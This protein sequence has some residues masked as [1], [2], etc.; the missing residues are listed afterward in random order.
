MGTIVQIFEPRF[1]EVCPKCGSRTTQKEDKFFCK[2]HDIVE[3]AFSYVFNVSLDDGTGTI[4]IGLFRNQAERLAGKT[5]EEMLVYRES[6]EKF[7]DVKT[8]ILGTIVKFVGR[9]RKNE[10]FDRLEFNA[11]FVDPSPNPEQELER[12][13]KEE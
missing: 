1:F 3:P 7:E 11:N 13:K 2:M 10:M 8:K 6:P 5:N 9:V 12:L 4:R